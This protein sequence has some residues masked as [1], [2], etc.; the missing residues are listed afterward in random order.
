MKRRECWSVEP[1]GKFGNLVGQVFGQLTV[2]SYA[3][4]RGC[5]RFWECACVCGGTK[6]VRT[7]HL[8]AGLI[9]SCG[10]VQRAYRE[11]FGG[12]MK[13]RR[14]SAHPSWRGGVTYRNATL[15]SMKTGAAKRGHAWELTNE[16]TFALMQ[17]PCV[18]CG[19]PPSNVRIDPSY[20]GHETPFA[21]SGI[22]RVDTSMGYSLDNAVPSCRPCNVA[23]GVL[24][25]TEWRHRM[26][27]TL[28]RWPLLE[29]EIARLRA[30]GDR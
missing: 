15:R 13:G 9:R 25:L 3:G 27:A 7:N 8:R 22:D 11:Q 10:C 1:T 30:G 16:E 14:E 2:L 21:Y 26:E 19:A 20:K 18:Y 17:Q 29:A 23:K 28:L 4:K 6:S 5:L 24:A 12:S